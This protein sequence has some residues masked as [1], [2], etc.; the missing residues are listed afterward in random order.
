MATTTAKTRQEVDNMSKA[1]RLWDSL[2]Y[3]YGRKGDMLNKE[4]DRAYSQADRQ[5]LSRG[6]QRSTYN[7]QTLANVN[8]NRINALNDNQ[9]ALIA[10]YENRLGQLEEQEWQQDFQ[11]RQFAKN[12]RQYNE[13]LAWDKEKA[14]TTA[15]NATPLPI[16]SGT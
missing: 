15:R 2:S 8:E 3:S 11:E 4:Y 10:D 1:D 14:A 12:Q 6:M 9:S 16:T 13:N 5:A 7:N